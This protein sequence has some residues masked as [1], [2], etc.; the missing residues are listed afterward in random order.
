MPSLGHANYALRGRECRLPGDT[1]TAEATV[2]WIAG[3]GVGALW[4]RGCVVERGLRLRLPRLLLLALLAA[5]LGLGLDDLGRLG[6]HVDR[7]RWRRG[8]RGRRLRGR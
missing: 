5:G 7:R 6:V 4:R 3:G 1:S 8:W 2:V